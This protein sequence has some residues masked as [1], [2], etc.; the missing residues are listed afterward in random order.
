MTHR[1]QCWV[2]GKVTLVDKGDYYQCSECGATWN[3][4]P[5]LGEFVDIKRERGANDGRLK[6]TPVRKTVRVAVTAKRKSRKK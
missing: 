3:D 1:K 6:Y 5:A 4:L 2:C